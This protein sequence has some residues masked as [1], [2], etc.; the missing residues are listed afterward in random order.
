MAG[1]GKHKA[2]PGGIATRRVL[3]PRNAMGPT[4]AN[5]AAGAHGGSGDWRCTKCGEEGHGLA[6]VATRRAA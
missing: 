6:P 3:C 5:W 2:A 4:P 1:K